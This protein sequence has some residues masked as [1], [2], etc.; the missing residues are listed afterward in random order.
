MLTLYDNLQL[1]LFLR[2]IRFVSNPRRTV[3]KFGALIMFVVFWEFISCIFFIKLKIRNIYVVDMQVSFSS[4]YA[5]KLFLSALRYDKYVLYIF[6]EKER[7]K[8]SIVKNKI[9]FFI[10]EI[11]T[12]TQNFKDFLSYLKIIFFIN[13]TVTIT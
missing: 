6:L 4:K 7:W 1:L 10:W 11:I 12:I 5:V 8:L 13:N 9:T 3:F 2:S